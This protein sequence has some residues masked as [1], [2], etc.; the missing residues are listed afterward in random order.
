MV[1][2]LFLTEM[3]N[4]PPL[5]FWQTRSAGRLLCCTQQSTFY[6]GENISL[7]CRYSFQRA[8]EEKAELINE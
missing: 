8:V 1:F 5:I 7:I 2:L 3:K 6:F 4:I